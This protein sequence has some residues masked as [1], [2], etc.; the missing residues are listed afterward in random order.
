MT[1]MLGNSG[2]ALAIAEVM[3]PGAEDAVMIAGDKDA[4]LWT[5]IHLCQNCVMSGPLDLAMLIEKADES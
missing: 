3:A 5:E 1:Q 4:S 2:Q